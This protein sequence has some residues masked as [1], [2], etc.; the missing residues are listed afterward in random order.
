MFWGN[1]LFSFCLGVHHHFSLN[2]LPMTSARSSVLLW[3]PRSLGA[4]RTPVWQGRRD[5][6]IMCIWWSGS[7]AKVRAEGKLCTGRQ[8][9]AGPHSC[10]FVPWGSSPW[11]LCEG[12]NSRDVFAP[13]AHEEQTLHLGY[14]VVSPTLDTLTPS[15][16]EETPTLLAFILVLH[17][18][19][20]CS[21][22]SFKGW[23]WSIPGVN[24]VDKSAR[25]FALNTGILQARN[26]G[27][28]ESYHENLCRG[29]EI[30]LIIKMC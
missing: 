1:K 26:L 19:P 5:P 12:Q 4:G 17:C 30:S 23:R 11:I 8:N 6:L 18:H 22:S 27:V 25:E 2:L 20:P 7:D 14:P 24:S 16:H 3:Q 28:S 15:V 9:F 10:F 29:V 21:L 13:S